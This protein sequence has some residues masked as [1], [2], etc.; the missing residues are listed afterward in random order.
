LGSV[1]AEDGFYIVSGLVEAKLRIDKF[2]APVVDRIVASA[3]AHT[4]DWWQVTCNQRPSIAAVLG[5][6]Q[7]SGG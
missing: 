5:D 6:P 3:E 7:M 1:A 4:A 2:T